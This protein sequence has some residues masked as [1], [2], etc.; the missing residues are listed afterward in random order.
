MLLAGCSSRPPGF[1]PV[2]AAQRA[3]VVEAAAKL[4]EAFNTRLGCEA[5][6]SGAGQRFQTYPKERWLADCARLQNDLGS[7]QT[8][9]AASIDRCAMP[10]AVVCMLGDGAFAKGERMLELTWSVAGGQAHLSAIGWREDQ[11]WIR[12]PP[13][14]SNRK[15]WDTPPVPGRRVSGRTG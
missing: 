11:D 6:Y 12:I 9:R 14:P 5:I 15:H 3:S 8:F 13:I 4:R 1:P 7:W 2:D 10:E